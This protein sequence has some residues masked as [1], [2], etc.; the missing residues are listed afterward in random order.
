MT[1]WTTTTY[2]PADLLR[3]ADL[4][5]VGLQELLDLAHRM[6]A[7][8]GGWLDALPGLALTCLYDTPSTQA[9]LSAEVAAHRLGLA[10][11]RVLPEVLALDR[12]EPPD[13]AIRVLARY[14]AVVLARGIPEDTLAHLA[15]VADVPVVN[16]MSPR[17]H[18]CQAVADLLTLRERFDGLAGVALAYVGYPGNVA[19]SL[20]EAGAMAA[21]DVRVACPAEH[22]LPP[23]DQTAAEVLADLH[24]GKVTIT[25]DPEEA[26]ADA[27]ALATAPWP[28][29]EEAADRERLVAQLRPYR[30]EPPLMARAKRHAVFLHCLPADRSAE[31]SAAV[32]D[33]PHSVVW[34]EAA[35]R[36]PS[37]QAAIFALA[38]AGGT[39]VEPE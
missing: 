34:E 32:I 2:W 13:D 22:P 6:R 24:G 11:I 17:H 23:E 3:V 1:S 10:P 35:N 39:M 9:G 25:A 33:G 7:E 18:P 31:V 38:T 37:E 20:V 27:D 28:A 29:V 26:A 30:V 12:G 21:M 16:A 36:I 15:R 14:T 4:T 8:P 5:G 19:R